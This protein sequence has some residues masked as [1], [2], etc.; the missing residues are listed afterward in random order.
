MRIFFLL[1]LCP[2]Y[3]ISQ[4]FS[5]TEIAAWEKRANNVTI[6]RDNWGVPHIYGKTD[7]DA[8]FGLMY[9]QCEDNFAEVE[10]NYVK[11]MGRLAEVKGPTELYNDLRVRLVTDVEDAKSDFKGLSPYM[12]GILNAFADGVNY[13]IHKSNTTPKLLQ[14][15]EPW[16]PL[17]WT[18]GSIDHIN[19]AGIS[20]NDIRDFYFSGKDLGKIN[21]ETEEITRGSNVF[22]VAPSRSF[23]GSAMLY[24][25]PHV[26]FNARSEIHMVS[27][28]GLNVYGAVAW[29]QFFVY[30]GFN[31][32]CGWMHTSSQ[33]DAADLYLEKLKITG[34]TMTYLYDGKQ[35]PVTKKE[36]I[37]NFATEEEMRS[38]KVTG[39]YTD[40]GPILARSGESYISL[41]ASNR[42]VKSLLQN[43]ERGKVK[44]FAEFK[45]NMSYCSEVND[46][47]TYADAQGNIAHWHGN[48][49]P[50]RDR[51]FNWSEP[52]D[53]TT[54]A[55]EWKGIH[56]PDETVHYEN[57]SNGWIQ[58]CNSSPFYSSGDASPKKESYPS[59]MAPDGENFRSLNARRLLGAD[60]KLSVG[61]LIGI[62]YDKT[63]AAFEILIPALKKAF[64]DA[65][66]INA[67][68]YRELKEPIEL[69]SAWDYKV[70]ENSVATGLAVEWA[71]KLKTGRG[72]KNPDQ[73]SKL[74]SFVSGAEPG[75]LLDPLKELINERLVK[76]EGW[77]I[78][79]GGINIYQRVS[80]ARGEVNDDSRPYYPMPWASATWGMLP[81]FESRYIK[82]SEVRYGVH[83][84][85]FVCAVEFGKKIKARSLLA[86][87]SSAEEG[88]PHYD[89]QV[90]MYRTGTF[91]DVYFYKED[92]LKKA[93]RTY[94]PGE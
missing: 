50:V 34:S 48:F 69:L 6:I 70:D 78:E 77:E 11:Y 56:K 75:D 15:F 43:W 16:F 39:L 26:Y 45:K 57:P 17:I 12:K 14:R 35:K 89:D 91:K 55:T 76:F 46:N 59:Y 90:D 72:N 83:G 88:N 28:E 23:S 63:L 87:G 9:A 49:I 52:V 65:N 66:K 71:E 10:I 2:V 61:S 85:S 33:A 40:H 62:G 41:K 24:I 64:A 92:L 94:H 1:L 80:S 7:A 27:E 21:L 44:S 25:N 30:Q 47:T 53:G 84:N 68:T 8:V 79:W 73:I 60:K 74:I 31:D 81:S 29:G 32:F 22:A 67:D 5:D 42:S 37:L 86:G 82:N 36:I 13:Y 93:E 3:T 58:N 20:V 19:T 54:S 38:T 51:K 4:N 18:H